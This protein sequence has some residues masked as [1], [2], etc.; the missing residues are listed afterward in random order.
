MYPFG[1]EKF[2]LQL[3]LLKYIICYFIR[4]RTKTTVTP[5]SEFESESFA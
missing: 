1:I 3:D 4:G 5:R 2:R